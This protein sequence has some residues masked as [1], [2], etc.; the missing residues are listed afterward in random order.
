MKIAPIAFLPVFILFAQ[1]AADAFEL[2]HPHSEERRLRIELEAQPT[3]LQKDFDNYIQE[4]AAA[5]RRDVDS[6]PEKKDKVRELQ[7]KAWNPAALF[8]W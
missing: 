3:Q 8:R 6:P 1:P 5:A 7:E 4:V 2:K